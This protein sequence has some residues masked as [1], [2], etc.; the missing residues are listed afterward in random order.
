MTY[1]KKELFI[2]SVAYTEENGV[3]Y[4]G[5][6]LCTMNGKN[7]VFDEINMCNYPKIDF[8]NFRTDGFGKKYVI[9]VHPI[10]EKRN[11]ET[12]EELIEVAKC[13]NDSWANISIPKSPNK[14]IGNEGRRLVL[15]RK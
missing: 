11:I 3:C 10:Y 14:S 15:L 8:V 1:K 13:F 9:D 2:S 6:I 5:E 12:L 7:M 4:L